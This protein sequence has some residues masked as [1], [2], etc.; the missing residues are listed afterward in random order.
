[1][2]CEFMVILLKNSRLYYA[3]NC[4]M[5]CGPDSIDVADIYSI[6]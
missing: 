1:M 2:S 4:R 5:F 3:W 6:E